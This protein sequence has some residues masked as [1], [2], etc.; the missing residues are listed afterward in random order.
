MKLSCIAKIAFGVV[1]AAALAAGCAANSENGDSSHKTWPAEPLR[2]I[3]TSLAPNNPDGC[4][5]EAFFLK[6]KEWN[7]NLIRF[8]INVDAKSPW[9]VKRGEKTPPIPAD[10]PMKPYAKHMENL[11]KALALAAKHHVFVIPTLGDVVGR[12][13]DVMLKNGDDASY[14]ANV[15]PIWVCIAKKHGA[16]PWLLAYDLLNEPNGEN[17]KIWTDDLVKKAIA[18]IRAIDKETYIVYEPAPWALPDQAF[19]KIKPLDDPKIVYSFHFYYPHCY[20]HQGIHSYKGPDYEGKAYPGDLRIFPD[21]PLIK[22][23]K[24]QLEKSMR[25]AIL[26]Q[27]TY[28]VRIWIGEFSAIRWAP[29]ADRWV[30]DA[31]DIFESHGWD[32]CFHCYYEWNGWDPTFDAKDPQGAKVDGGKVTERLK[33]LQKAWAK[34]KS[35]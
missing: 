14:Y 17:A 18:E 12:K 6:M 15:A 21:A 29:G 11:D 16:N 1:G 34:N 30:K 25:N 32:W 13:N 8:P 5:D 10:D 33:I 35:Y 28:K 27:E 20:T 9:D 24:A 31:V 22:W 19:E 23:D 3:N 2:G 4:L 26:F 7:V